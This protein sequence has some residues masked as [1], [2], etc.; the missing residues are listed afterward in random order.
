MRIGVDSRWYNLEYW[1][2]SLPLGMNR[3][4]HS[5][6]ICMLQQI[7]APMIKFFLKELLSFRSSI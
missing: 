6:L 5:I 4:R 2:A 1:L 3:R 7:A